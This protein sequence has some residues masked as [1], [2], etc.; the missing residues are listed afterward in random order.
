VLSLSLPAETPPA[1]W[2]Q[3]WTVVQWQD[4][5]GA[6]HDV[7]GWRGALDE[8]AFGIGKK[9]WVVAEKDLGTGPFAWFVYAHPG[10]ELAAASPPFYL[11]AQ[12]GDIFESRVIGP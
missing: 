4:A 6:W 7:T 12:A 1:I 8:A 10:G 5:A 3:L 2:S 9:S 11:P